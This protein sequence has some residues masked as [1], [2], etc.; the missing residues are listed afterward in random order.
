M[1]DL[2]YCKDWSYFAFPMNLLGGLVLLSGIGILTA[3]YRNTSWV[4]GLSGLKCTFI[5]TVLFVAILVV[6]G[7]WAFQ[8]FRTWL[9]VLLL[10]V[11]LLHLGLV[12]A[13][14]SRQFSWRNGLFLLNHGGLWI[15]IAAALLGAPD[16]RTLKMIS[17][18]GRADYMAIDAE[19]RVCPLPFTVTLQNFEADYYAGSGGKPRNF[20][21]ELLL[22]SRREKK[23]VIV[24]VN[25]PV[26]FEGY[27]VYQD[28]YDPAKGSDS[29]Y[30]VLQMVRDPWWG[31]VY[32]GILMMIAGA[33]G[34]I[35][36][37]PLKKKAYGIRLE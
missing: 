18:R 31:G 27:A 3:F 12:I 9:F 36:A 21:S 23:Q 10:L 22:Q 25:H 24:E 37:G 7:I 13:W 30:V 34:L 28:G 8:L 26:K 4:K 32:A 16:S 35:M 1:A 33:V 5:L 29:E 17:F 2:F 20:R 14:H 6:E 19:G 11:L 15:T